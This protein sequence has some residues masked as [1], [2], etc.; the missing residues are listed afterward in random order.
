MRTI[1]NVQAVMAAAL[2]AATAQAGDVTVTVDASVRHQTILGWGAT[3]PNIDVPEGLADQILDEAVN[4]LG[5]TRLRLEPPGGNYCDRRRWEW[6]NDNWDPDQ[7][8][9]A[10][11]N[12][13]E[14]DEHVRRW[15]VPFKRRVE[16]NGEP[17]NLYVSPSFFDGGSSGRA[18]AWLLHNPAEYAEHA[19]ALL[20]RL[21]DE[22]D[23]TA[24]YYCICNEAG[25][26][27]AFSAAV[28][29][30]M[31]KAVGRRLA[32]L[33]LPT[34]IEF[35]ECVNADISWDYIQ[36][37]K[38][39]PEVWQYVG[40]VTYHLYGRNRARSKIRDFARAKGLPTG[41]T[42]YMG[43]TINH[44][45]ADL[46]LGG[47]SY[48]EHYVLAYYGNRPNPGDYFAANY[49]MTSFTRYKHYWDFRQV[50]H[51]VRPG[52][53]RI[54]AVSDDKGLRPLAFIRDGKTTLVLLNNKPPSHARTVTIKGLG[55]GAYGLC[56]SV[57]G[58]VY[59]ELGVKTV[60]RTGGLT[61]DVPAKAVLT[62]YPRRGPHPGTNQPPT[63]TEW[64]A[65]P[66][67]LTVPTGSTTLSATATDAELDGLGY[68][69]SV[70][71]QPAG[72]NVMLTS[73]DQAA[74]EASGL[75]AAG[76][77]VFS[78]TVSD[79]SNTATRQVA[80]N[81]H[82]ANEPPVIGD[83]HNRLPVV[84]TL[85]TSGTTLRGYARDLE[86]ESLTYKWSLVSRP[87][88]ATVALETPTKQG[89]KATGMTVAGDYVFRLHASD[90]THTVFK[91]LTVH[92]YPLNRAP[93]ISGASA[94]PAELTLPASR[95]TLSARMSDPD[96]DKM[97]Q[98]WSVKSAPAGVD[99]AL[100]NQSSAAT[101]AIGLTA[102]GEYVFTLTVVDR[103]EVSTREVTVT[104]HPP[105]NRVS[106]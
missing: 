7:I 89:C 16:A 10:G 101:K 52:A 39:D 35:P 87:D 105:A 58:G 24:D 12:T 100:T 1:H 37:L 91:D 76:Q 61:V 44:L 14:L 21:R 46:T 59:Q 84:V 104:V 20:L 71:R 93:V 80:L 74:T 90:S 38:D 18:P 8:D 15:V 22:H 5:L 72:A 88:G 62:I 31:I 4:Q 9:W 56:Q 42:E 30:R 103:S 17:F 32:R 66:S 45:Y 77:Y 29:G 68:A 41:Q 99:C 43:T 6:L 96:G 51:Y 25:N 49:N 94:S 78:V 11:F 57:G 85:P 64:R 81:V 50:M 67:Y 23:I 75:A 102:A 34:K 65:E 79:G 33:G 95:T 55:P 36:A 53:V 73:P 60:E 26:G 13:A 98:F 2:F 106:Q 70:T 82:A 28:V 54:E 69:W 86:G 19:A 47:V 92:V 48:W 27:N 40:V 3:A 63:I 83:L 97:G